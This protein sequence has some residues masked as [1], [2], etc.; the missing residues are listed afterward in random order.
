MLVLALSTLAVHGVVPS[1]HGAASTL[2]ADLSHIFHFP[3]LPISMHKLFPSHRL[4]FQVRQVTVGQR[5]HS[6]PVAAHE[7]IQTM[8]MP[9]RESGRCSKEMFQPCTGRFVE[10]VVVTRNCDQGL[11]AL[12][13]HCLVR[14]VRKDATVLWQE[15]SDK[16]ECSCRFSASDEVHGAFWMMW[17]YCDGRTGS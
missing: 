12:G 11:R 14:P 16:G 13:C 5:I 1:T 9:L 4:P 10:K 8:K 6:N 15:L 3:S 2:H 17:M 7:R